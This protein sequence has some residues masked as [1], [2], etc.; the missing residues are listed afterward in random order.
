MPKM[1]LLLSQRQRG[2]AEVYPLLRFRGIRVFM[3][4][5]AGIQA[6]RQH[7]E[8]GDGADFYS[9]GKTSDGLGG[10]G[11]GFG[12][13]AHWHLRCRI[14]VGRQAFGFAV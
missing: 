6:Q 10:S 5:Q 14:C 8:P 2:R 11:A 7:D 3:R 4:R 1:C 12:Q 9:D 13:R